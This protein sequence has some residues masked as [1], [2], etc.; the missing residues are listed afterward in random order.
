[1]LFALKK[2]LD[3]ATATPMHV[4]FDQIQG[5]SLVALRLCSHFEN[6]KFLPYGKLAFITL[7]FAE[8]TLFI[9]FQHVKN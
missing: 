3:I 9:N 6:E 2:H 5:T 8:S 1:M 4:H 7:E